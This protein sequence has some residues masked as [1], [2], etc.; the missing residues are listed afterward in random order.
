MFRAQRRLGSGEF[1]LVPWPSGLGIWFAPHNR[2][3]IGS[4]FLSRE[5]EAFAACPKLVSHVGFGAET[6]PTSNP[7]LDCFVPEADHHRV[8]TQPCAVHDSRFEEAKFS[9]AFC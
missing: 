5:E 4:S 7:G 1:A 6:S 8:L 2:V 9:I 3:H